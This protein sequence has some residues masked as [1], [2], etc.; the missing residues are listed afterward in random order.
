MMPPLQAA[1]SRSAV[2]NP[3]SVTPPPSVPVGFLNA[4][5]V[6]LL[7]FGFAFSFSA[8]ATNNVA[9]GSI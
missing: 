5:G 8:R 1:A 6:R 2:A 7:G 9:K 4:A 3:D